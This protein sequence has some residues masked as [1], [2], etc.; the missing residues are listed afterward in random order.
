MLLVDKLKTARRLFVLCVRT[1]PLGLALLL[2]LRISD[3]TRRLLHD[4]ARQGLIQLFLGGR[5]LLH[6]LEQL[7]ER[8][9]RRFKL[10]DLHQKLRGAWLVPLLLQKAVQKAMLLHIPVRRKVRVSQLRF[11]P[12]LRLGHIGLHHVVGEDLLPHQLRFALF[13]FFQF[14]RCEHVRTPLYL[15]NSSAAPAS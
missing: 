12:R 3:H 15:P 11:R 14:L 5:V 1:L 4:H 2:L 9:V 13:L 7:A 10:S 8:A 6:L